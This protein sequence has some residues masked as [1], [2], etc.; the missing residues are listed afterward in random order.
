M[1]EE[2]LWKLEDELSKAIGM[3]ALSVV[4]FLTIVGLSVGLIINL[5]FRHEI[6]LFLLMSLFFGAIVY[7]RFLALKSA[8]KEYKTL[9]RTLK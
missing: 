2:R 6:L 5:G 8:Y 3:F 4:F 1:N 7:I 9:K